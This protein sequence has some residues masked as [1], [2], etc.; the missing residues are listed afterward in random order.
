[1]LIR[2]KLWPSW[3]KADL[4]HNCFCSKETCVA[5]FNIARDQ[6]VDFFTK[7]ADVDMR[8][9]YVSRKSGPGKHEIR[10]LHQ[11]AL[12]MISQ[13]V[14]HTNLLKRILADTR[15]LKTDSGE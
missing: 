11:Q 4:P 15:F 2:R 7:N 8:G 12:W 10:D 1:M 13:T 5:I 9:Y 3:Q 14:R 6:S